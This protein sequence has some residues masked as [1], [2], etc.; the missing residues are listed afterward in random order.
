MARI[1]FLH[2][3]LG[4]G[5]AERL[6]VDAALGLKKKGNL[7]NIVTTHHDKNRA[8]EETINGEISV[9]VVGDWIPRSFFN[10]FYALLAYIR[11]IYAAF[12]IIFFSNINP[13]VVF[14]DLVSVAVPILKLKIKKVIF[15]CH[16]PDQL[17]SR[18]EGLLKALY[19]VPINWVEE[20]STGTANH[21]FVNSEF[22]AG[23]FKKTFKKINI[24]PDILYPSLNMSFFDSFKDSDLKLNYPEKKFYFLSINRY[25]RKKNLN[26][27]VRS[28]SELKNIVDKN[29]WNEVHLIMAGGY[30]SR[31]IENVEHYKELTQLTRDLNLSDKVT[32]LKSFTDIEKISLLKMCTCLIYTPS[33]EH[34][35]I[36]PIEAMYMRKPV[37]AVNSGG[38]TETIINDVTGYLC[39]P[40]PESFA[41]A[42]SKFLLNENLSMKLGN[43]GKERVLST[44]SFDK[45]SLKLNNVVNELLGKKEN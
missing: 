25:E 34:F 4:I 15:Y 29:L 21:I 38:P 31:V 18:P 39:D 13:D 5:G 6:V 2:P 36:V 11:M 14:C 20:I 27:A 10:R 19:R 33:N 35:G 43:A 7:V 40:L 16:F 44:F 9:I 3:D 1:T 28:L 12:Y 41:V 17:L 30:D 42:M 45:F 22:T 37:I 8:F 32:F 23:V 26:L 24:H